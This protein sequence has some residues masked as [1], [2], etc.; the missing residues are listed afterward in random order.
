MVS[1]LATAHN[2]P[3][4]TAQTTRCFFLSQIR[5]DKGGPLK[6]CGESPASSEHSHHHAEGDGEATYP[7][8]TS[9][10]GA[11][12]SEPHARHERTKNSQLMQ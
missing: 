4:R 2:D 6:E 11:S 12:R 8:S 1:V 5:E 9:L 7:E 3:A 10:V